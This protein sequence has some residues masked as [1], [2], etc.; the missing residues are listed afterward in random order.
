[1]ARTIGFRMG[2]SVRAAGEACA[3]WRRLGAGTGGARCCWCDRSMPARE[4]DALQVAVKHAIQW[5]PYCMYSAGSSRAKVR[6]RIDHLTEYR[7]FLLAG[8]RTHLGIPPYVRRHARAHGRLEDPPAHPA[9]TCRCATPHEIRC[10]A[11]MQ[12]FRHNVQSKLYF[13]ASITLFIVS[14]SLQL[15]CSPVWDT[16]PGKDQTKGVTWRDN[17][18]LGHGLRDL[19]RPPH[20][21]DVQ[22][23]QQKNKC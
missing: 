2:C 1:M 14:S 19:I 16:R 3:A 10:P 9:H 11:C 21:Q 15:M 5:L 12:S 13:S 23:R 8:G 22:K 4:L 20:I 17:G 6:P 18:C 7:A